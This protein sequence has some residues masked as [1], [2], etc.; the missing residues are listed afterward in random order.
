MS[1]GPP[2]EIFC[3]SKAI[4]VLETN[5]YT[6]YTLTLLYSNRDS[7]SFTFVVIQPSDPTSPINFKVSECSSSTATITWT[8]G[9]SGNAPTKRQA[10][11]VLYYERE[12]VRSS[13]LQMNIT[14]TYSSNSKWLTNG[15]ENEMLSAQL[16]DLKPGTQYEFALYAENDNGGKSNL[17]N[18]V[19]CTTKPLSRPISTYHYRTDHSTTEQITI[20]TTRVCTSLFIVQY[21]GI[22][23]LNKNVIYLNILHPYSYIHKY[24]N[25]MVFIINIHV[26]R[27]VARVLLVGGG[28]M[29]QYKF[30]NRNFSAESRKIVLLIF[31]PFKTSKNSSY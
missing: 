14:T 4:S 27:A 8:A 25:T 31:K 6:N 26:Y 23:K 12:S 16:D 13:E 22:T 18:S 9:L 1:A 15:S 30:I 3:F 2:D 28:K 7:K 19:N 17:T 10:F 21:M 29:G 24:T 11:H 20:S 5:H